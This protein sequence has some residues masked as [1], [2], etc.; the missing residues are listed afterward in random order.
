MD[1]VIVYQGA[2]PLEMDLLNTNRNILIALG[3]LAQDILGTSTVVGGL[4][5]TP[6]APASLNVLVGAG[7]IYSQEPVDSTAYSS[8]PVDTTDTIVK[9]GINLNTT[10]LSC[11]APVS[12]G[13]SI[14]YLI[15]GTYQDQDADLVTLPYYNSTNPA[16]PFSGP[17][18]QGTQQATVRAGVV[19]LR[20]KAGIPAPSGTQSTPSADPGYVGLYVVTVAFGQTAITSSN[21]TVAPNAPFI[22]SLLL[23]EAFA[24]TRYL[25]KTGGTMTGALV[26]T[27]AA[28]ASITVN[29]ISVQSASLL[30][31]GSVSPSLIPLAAVIQY[32]NSLQIAFTQVTGQIAAPQVPFGAVSQYQAS[33]SIGWGQLTGIK[34]ADY[35]GGYAPST[36]AGA[37]TVGVRDGSGY[38]WA[39]YFNQSS[40]NNENPSISQVMVTNGADNFLRKANLLSLQAQMSL[41]SIGG[42]VNCVSQLSGT[43]PNSHLPNVGLMPGVVI[44]ADPGGTPSGAPGTMYL[45]Y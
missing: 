16:S 27:T 2:V 6:T 28:F 24:D 20:A 37:N 25:Q 42:F 23:T 34:N 41:S 11:P 36:A 7:R 8:L 12:A 10:P 14:N 43:V 39:A 33:F 29:G 5:C 15:E 9:Q 17:N 26:G 44:Q 45:Y 35:V 21:I 38:F 13:Y 30:N 4:P 3:L 18:N 32:E 19:Q 31:S 40:G 22:A 1:R